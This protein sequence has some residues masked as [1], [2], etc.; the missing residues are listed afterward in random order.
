M[1]AAFKQITAEEETSSGSDSP[2]VEN[3][4]DSDSETDDVL[5]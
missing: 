5:R 1:V 2:V 4:S 3:D